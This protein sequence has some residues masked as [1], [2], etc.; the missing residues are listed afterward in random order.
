MTRLVVDR[1]VEVHGELRVHEQQ[2][3]AECVGEDFHDAAVLV[4]VLV[5]QRAASSR[6]AAPSERMGSKD[7]TGAV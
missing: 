5:H 7:H 1:V 3:C 4:P 6:P 2:S